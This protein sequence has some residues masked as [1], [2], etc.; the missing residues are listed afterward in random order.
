MVP[1]GKKLNRYL[2]LTNQTPLDLVFL[3][4]CFLV[5]ASVISHLASHPSTLFSRINHFP[6]ATSY[7]TERAEQSLKKLA[8][9]SPAYTKVQKAPFMYPSESKTFI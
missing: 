2:R 6:L 1:C 4:F 3:Q 9:R 7:A 8:S 5:K